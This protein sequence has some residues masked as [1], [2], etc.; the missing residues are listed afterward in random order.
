MTY[1]SFKDKVLYDKINYTVVISTHFAKS[2]RGKIIVEI[3][4]LTGDWIATLPLEEDLKDAEKRGE[5]IS[6]WKK[7]RKDQKRKEY[8]QE[9][10]DNTF[11]LTNTNT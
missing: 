10:F 3:C 1:L 4:K 2:E 7:F 8:T 6:F 11:I 5:D 9:E